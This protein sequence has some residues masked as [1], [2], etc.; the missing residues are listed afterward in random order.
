MPTGVG[1]EQGFLQQILG[2]RAG[3]SESNGAPTEG[4]NQR[5]HI[6]FEADGDGRIL[7]RTDTFSACGCHGSH[8]FPNRAS[9]LSH[10][11]HSAAEA[12]KPSAMSANHEHESCTSS[13]AL[14]AVAL[15]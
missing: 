12:G 10:V 15:S 2:I 14:P 3:G 8:P 13:A 9:V 11:D 1:F 7:C 5:Y 6:T 4:L